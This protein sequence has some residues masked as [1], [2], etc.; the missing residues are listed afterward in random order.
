MGSAT[1]RLFL[2]AALGGVWLAL[3]FLGLTLGG[4]IHLLAAGA[5]AAF[6]WR[7]AFP[8]QAMGEE[9]EGTGPEGG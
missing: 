3:L 7:E 9:G 5:L 4:A 2:C 1:S 6:P 8:R